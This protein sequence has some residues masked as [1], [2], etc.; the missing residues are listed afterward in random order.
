MVLVVDSSLVPAVIEQY[1]SN[2]QVSVK[3]GDTVDLVCMAS[4]RPMPEVIWKYEGNLVLNDCYKDTTFTN[5][6]RSSVY[7]IQNVRRNNSGRYV[8]HA[9][10]SIIPPATANYFVQVNYVPEVFAEKTWVHAGIGTLTELV[11][12]VDAVPAAQVTWYRG[13]NDRIVP[14]RHIFITSDTN[15]SKHTLRFNGVRDVDFGVYTCKAENF[16]GQSE[17]SIEISGKAVSATLRVDP[18][19]DGNQL[20]MEGR[21]HRLVWEVTSHTPI[22]EYRLWLHPR[23][24]EDKWINITIGLPSES[25]TP[26]SHTHFYI[27]STPA[28]DGNDGVVYE[29]TV[30]SRNKFGWSAA[31]NT[32]LVT[33][34]SGHDTGYTENNC[35]TSSI[36]EQPI[37]STTTVEDSSPQDE[38]IVAEETSISSEIPV[39]P[40]LSSQ[41]DPSD[42]PQTTPVNTQTEPTVAT[43]TESCK[44][45]GQAEEQATSSHSKSAGTKDLQCPILFVTVISIIQFSLRFGQ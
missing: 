21:R 32:V 44:T 10:N 34:G 3:E 6:T 18:P 14:S 39:T 40:E 35:I 42:L 28:T 31:S 7:Q 36:T 16:L 15:C 13:G 12:H 19:R 9:D 1:P 37:K 20:E 11:C 30:E 24:Q 41:S 22:I 25:T 4:G 29:I 45:N 27:L 33:V 17:V 23:N 26:F 2:G 5:S 38:S 43:T 8:C